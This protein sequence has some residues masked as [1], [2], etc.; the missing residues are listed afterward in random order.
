MLFSKKLHDELKTLIDNNVYSK[1]RV[2]IK[3]GLISSSIDKKIKSSKGKIIYTIK[4]LHCICALAT[5]SCIKDLTEFP[6]VK[7]ICLDGIATLCAKNVL[8]SNGIFIDNKIYSPLKNKDISGKNICIGIIDSGIYPHID[9]SQPEN[10]IKGFVDLLNYMKYPYDDNGH[11][12]FISGIISGKSDGKN[13]K[14]QGIAVDS[15]LFMV[16]AFNKYGKGYISATLYALEYLYN[17]S[18]EYNIKVICIPFE[19]E[20]YNKFILNLYET[21]F[22]KF[23]AKN[24]I[25]T[26]PAGN[27]EFEEDT[28]KGIA[29]SKNILTIGGMDTNNS[30][31]ISNYSCSGSTKVLKKPDFIAASDEISSLNSDCSYISELNGEKLYPHPLTS[32]Y[33]TKSGTSIACAFVAGI[34]AL[35]FEVNNSFTFEDIYSLLKINSVLIDEKKYKQGNGY[36][37]MSK[38]INTDFSKIKLSNNNIKIK[39]K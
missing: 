38:L 5:K 13:I 3:Y 39:K 11:G 25:V 15:N 9:L 6:E 33:V 8:H 18:E 10:K 16:K 17:I 28:I 21:L 27:N 1:Y 24:I 32:K 30:Y 26:A 35:L 4:S 29:L 31:S 7:F 34:C 37:N 14:Q 36:I 19:V 22:T 12:T 20:S 2:I 23:K